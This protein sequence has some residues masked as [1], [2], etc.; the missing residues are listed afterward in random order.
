VVFTNLPLLTVAFGYMCFAYVGWMFLFWI[1]TYLV[2]ARGYPL[3]IMGILGIPLQGSAFIGLVGGGMLGDWLL[4]RGWS[5]QFV[6]ARM[7]GIGLALS[8]PFLLAGALVPSASLCVV[9]LIIFY[10]LFTSALACYS[11]VAIEFNQHLAGAIFG[12]INTLGTFAGF[13]GPLTAGY[14][15][16][17]S[18]GNWLIPFFVDTAIAAVSAMILLTVP[19]R[20]IKVEG[21]APA[22]VPVGGIVH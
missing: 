21:V 16:T 17:G 20:P 14:M 10:G 1:P 2:E 8:L 15:L 19:I 9:C 4:R 18:G 7:G 12:L 11:T 6:R 13:L 22:A 3:G 5:S